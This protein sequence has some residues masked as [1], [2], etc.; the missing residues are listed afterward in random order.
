MLGN[1]CR[2][3]PSCSEHT[4]KSIQNH[5]MIKGIYLGLKQIIRCHPFYKP[6]KDNL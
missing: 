4:Y 5:G 3:H 6:Q 2:F 1:N